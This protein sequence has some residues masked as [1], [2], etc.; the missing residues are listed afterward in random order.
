MSLSLWQ[1]IL[2]KVK[3]LVGSKY[4][5]M[6]LCFYALL[7]SGALIYDFLVLLPVILAV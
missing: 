3:S 7:A 6:D 2:L 5:G 4:L 1:K